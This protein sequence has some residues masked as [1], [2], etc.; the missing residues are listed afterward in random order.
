VGAACRPNR[1][2]RRVHRDGSHF[3]DCYRRAGADAGPRLDFPND[4]LLFVGF[5]VGG[6]YCVDLPLVQE[7]MPASKRGFVGGLMTAFIPL[8]VLLGSVVGAVLAPLVGW[9]G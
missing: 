3:L 4:I 9:R 6:L 7:F 1:T 8:G 5:G 2:T